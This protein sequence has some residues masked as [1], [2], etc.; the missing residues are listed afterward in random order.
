MCH[1]RISVRQGYV[2]GLISCPD[3]PINICPKVILCYDV[4]ILRLPAELLGTNG[5]AFSEQF[6]QL[7]FGAVLL[8]AKS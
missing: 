1:N 5:N 8:E 4:V 6:F 2:L 7:T 3:G